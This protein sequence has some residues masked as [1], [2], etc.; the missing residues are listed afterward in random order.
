M[1]PT[2][3]FALAAAAVLA[4]SASVVSAIPSGDYFVT[5]DGGYL[6][7]G[8]LENRSLFPK[9][10]FLLP[11]PHRGDA[12]WTIENLGS[13]RHKITV[14]GGILGNV[15]GELR[16]ILDQDASDTWSIVPVGRRGTYKILPY[17]QKKIGVV[18]PKNN[19]DV[20]KV[21]RKPTAWNVMLTK[22]SIVFPDDE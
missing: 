1:A 13:G 10:L 12:V 4:L 11:N 9:E 5:A 6:G 17:G 3:F 15:D 8:S 20:V 2:Q 21:G 19:E 14:G 7:R 16:A 18:S 22:N